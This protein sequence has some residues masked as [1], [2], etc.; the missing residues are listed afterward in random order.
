M[1]HNCKFCEALRIHK[2]EA[3]F[4]NN[5]RRKEGKPNVRHDYTVALV[6]RSW[7]KGS[8]KNYGSRT[9]DYRNQGIGYKL[10]F[11]PECGRALKR[12]REVKK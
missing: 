6:S 9:T 7:N 5:L 10:N 1:A 3:R 4:W 12:E 8:G 11:C 2:Q